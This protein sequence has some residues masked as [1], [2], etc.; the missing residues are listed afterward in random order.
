MANAYCKWCEEDRDGQSRGIQFQCNTCKRW[1]PQGYK[2]DSD[3]ESFMSNGKNSE[4]IV[5]TEKRVRTK[6][7][8]IEVCNIDTSIWEIEKW[9]VGKS[10]GYR[11]DK[12]SNWESVNGKGTGDSIDTGRVIV[13]PLYTVKVWLK[14]K[15]EEIRANLIIDSLIAEAKKFAPKYPK[16]KYE[17]ILDAHMM[18][19]ALPDLQ[20]GRLVSEFAT[21]YELNPEIQIKKAEDAIDQLIQYSKQFPIKRILF[22]VGNDFFDSNTAEMMTVHGTPQ[23]D[24]VRWQRT[25]ELGCQFL[26]KV[27]DK[28]MNIAPVDVLIIPGNH[29]EERI[30]Y[31]GSWLEAWYH[32]CQDVKVDNYPNKR[33]YFVCDNNLIMLTH[34]YYEKNGKL[35]S[36][37][38]YEVP[39]L[40]AKCQNREVHLGDKHHKVDMIM[41]TDE[42]ENGVVV[43]ILRSLATPSVWEHDKGLVGSLKASEMFIWHPTNGVVA[44][45]TAKA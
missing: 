34:G 38:A 24:D 7:E 21:G 2:Q 15:T 42:L 30:F 28:L 27:I 37:M 13:V 17:K 33:K 39:D 25:Y 3:N 5:K 41:K 6:E 31:L 29:D 32:N 43:R 1:T 23:Q 44:Q 4:Y 35:D 20:L 16:I 18:E 26:R 36:L 40:W 9:T 11:K 19:I 14:R 22:P 45:F 8:L 12:V 10:E